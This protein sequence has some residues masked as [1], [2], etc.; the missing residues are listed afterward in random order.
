MSKDEKLGKEIQVFPGA[1]ETCGSS[2]ADLIASSR[3]LFVVRSSTNLRLL[4]V[5]VHLSSDSPRRWLQD[6]DSHPPNY[7]Y[8]RPILNCACRDA[9]KSHLA[10]NARQSL[11]AACEPQGEASEAASASFSI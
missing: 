5:H 3:R 6:A 1:C 4:V 7:P 9:S 10:M 8:S 2:V 11:Q